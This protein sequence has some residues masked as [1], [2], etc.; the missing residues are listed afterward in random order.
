[1]AAIIE[2]EG[3]GE[4]ILSG[5]KAG[6]DAVV[7]LR[8]ESEKTTDAMK[9][10]AESA[11]NANKKMAVTIEATAQSLTDI[12][13]EAGGTAVIGK[14]FADSKKQADALND[15]L[16]ITEEELA[17]ATFAADAL[18]K[19]QRQIRADAQKI[20][21]AVAKGT[22][23]QSQGLKVAER[24]A[25]EYADNAREL[26]AMSGAAQTFQATITK[27][28][29]PTKSLREQ[30]KQAKEELDRI[31][32]ASDGKITPELIEAAQKAGQ[33]KDRF[34]D[35]NATVDAFNP[36]TKFKAVVGVLSNVASGAQAAAAGMGLF[37][38]ESEDVNKALLKIQQTTAFIQ[39]FQG[40]IGGLADNWKN[41]KTIILASSVATKADTVTKGANA[42]GTLAQAGATTVATGATGGFI[43]A[44][45]ALKVA[46]LSTPF[47]PVVLA[48]AAIGVATYAV[49]RDTK[50]YKAGVEELIVSLD[51][52]RDARFT[53]IDQDLRLKNIQAE[54]ESLEAGET[55]AAKRRQKEQTFIN[56]RGALVAKQLE[57]EFYL[58]SLIAEVESL[59]GVNTESADEARKVAIASLEKYS[60]EFQSTQFAIKALEEEQTNN[61]ISNTNE[62]TAAYKAAASKRLE[63]ERKLA[64]DIVAAEKSITDRL[65]K[66]QFDAAGPAQKLELARE[67]ALKE[68][69]IL[70]DTLKKKKALAEVERR[71]GAET[72]A[73]LSEAQKESRAQAL[74]DNGSVQLQVEQQEQI[75]SLQIA[76]WDRYWKERVDLD[77]ESRK[78]LLALQSEGF[79]K[80]R[81][82]FDMEL[83]ARVQSLVTAGATIVQ[84]EQY[85]QSERDKFRTGQVSKA[86]DQEE[87]IALAKIGAI[88][89]GAENE[90][91]FAYRIELEKLDTQEKFAK[92]RL[93][94][95]ANDGSTENELLRAQTD[96]AIAV[97]QAK[98]AELEASAPKLDLFDMLGLDLT[99][100][101][102]ERLLSD[103]A[104]IGNAVKQ[105]VQ[106]NI[107]AQQ[108]DVDNQI[109]ATDMIINDAQ[110]RREGLQGELDQA[111]EDKRAGYANDAEAIREQIQ[112]TV[113]EEKKGLAERKRLVGEQKKLAKQQ[114]IIDAAQQAAALALSI[115]R[116]ISSWSTIPFGVGLVA[117]FAQ[118]AAVVAT[119]AGIKARLKAES[120][121]A[122]LRKGGKLKGPSHE[123]G[124]VAMIDRRTGQQMAEAEGGEWVVNKVASKKHHDLIEALNEGD[125]GKAQ[126]AAIRD[127]LGNNIALESDKVREV[128]TLK[129]KE[130]HHHTTTVNEGGKELR[131]ELKA[132]RNDFNAFVGAEAARER[133][134]G[135]TTK[136]PG[137][138]KVR[139]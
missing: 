130:I 84:V 93:A 22:I 26:Q 129:E 118:G 36:D 97:I 48:L 83:D 62:R 126:K 69:A 42:A 6:K 24:L 9:A 55:E 104:E 80:D 57:N 112:K 120:N 89:R 135:N 103:L 68:V 86:I 105:A 40:L 79:E 8:V 33:L 131:K 100:E 43:T 4:N 16:G 133:T 107:A 111:L 66:E 1:M 49:L 132:L 59:R 30:L 27:A 138:V 37:G 28:D 75:T 39:G 81:A 122:T 88:Q 14:N 23:T 123:G 119:F 41:L 54:R 45:N 65:N 139:N 3:L 18:A 115:A 127:L 2:F 46:F 117:A 71:I 19:A 113:E 35:L 108:A 72:F 56:E 77:T 67:N 17:K 70:E 106:A 47:G 134:N 31:V 92:Q 60:A 21:E 73:A 114:I 10:G 85:I 25:A 125:M 7:S 98:R 63:I 5:L 101:N 64:D 121:S 137:I 44:L 110:R 32:E 90:Q 38:A 34:G 95:I 78:T 136:K 82:Q 51:K 53:Q 52:L 87:A 128:V 12:R 13:K 124:G 102:K 20:P 11:G 109:N 58:I 76:V 99:E 94:N 74:V 29:A 61:T 96:E 15:S 91:V 116:L 50:D